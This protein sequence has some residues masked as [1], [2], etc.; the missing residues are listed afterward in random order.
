MTDE[1][2][3]LRMTADTIRLLAADAVEKAGS[4]HP[5]MP[6]GCADFAISLWYNH[7]RHRPDSPDWLGRD[8]FVL[9]A[10]HGSNLLYALLHLFNYGL[11]Q[12]DLAQ[13]RQWGSLTPGHPEYGTTPGVEVTT[14]PLATGFGSAVGMAIASKQLAGRMGNEELFNQ[15]VY[16][17]SSDGCMMEGASHETASLAGHL[18]L[19][20][21][22]CFYDYNEITIEGGTH[23]AYSDEVNSRFKGYGW[24]V[25]EVDGHDYDEIEKALAEAEAHKDAPTLIIG[26]TTIGF[27]APDMAGS[28]ETHGAPLGEEEIKGVKKALGFPAEKTFYVPE[29]V[30]T[31][32]NE[33]CDVLQQQAEKWDSSLAQFLYNNPE[34]AD[35]L[36]NLREHRVPE[37]IREELLKAVPEKKLASRHAGGEILQRAAELVPA[38]VGGAADLAPSTKTPMKAEGD[39]TSGDRAGRNFHFGVREFGMGLCGNGLALYGAAIPYVSTFMVFSD[40]MKPAVRLAALQK[41]HEIYVFTHDSVFVGEDGPTHQPIE[42]LMMLRG[43]PG[44]TVIRPAESHE[45]AHAWAAALQHED[46]PV[47]LL[48]S[49]QKLE[50]FSEEL[51]E[52]IDLARGAY[53]L[54]EDEGFE[55]ILIATGSEVNSALQ[56]A[57]EMRCEGVKVRVVSMPSWELFEQQDAEYQ[58]SVLPSDCTKRVSVEAGITQGWDKY[59]GTDGLKI[60]VDHFGHSAPYQL[61]GEKYGLDAEGIAQSTLKWLRG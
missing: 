54:S 55:V 53:V 21:L 49:R 3:K 30:R 35:L 6:M 33:R 42:Q 40:F 17:L 32:I 14:G 19:D 22:I 36:K 38:L 24:H 52:R 2:K 13:F 43:I 10:G 23:L 26:H 18:Q 57:E 11:T 39:F 4:G 25:L 45:V 37:N 41:L 48:L 51:A 59:V 5:G 34:K 16:A 46:G 56:A 60:G 1:Q 47:A 31:F 20:N 29:E 61:L 28:H 50:N 8:R 9:S 7:L 27:G 12:D 58:E 15:H 44:I